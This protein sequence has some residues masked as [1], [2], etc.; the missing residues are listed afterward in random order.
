MGSARSAPWWCGLLVLASAGLVAAPPIGS[1]APPDDVENR[2]ARLAER[3]RLWREAWSHERAREFAEALP[4]YRAV[5][6]LDREL[7]GERSLTVAYVLWR[8]YRCHLG[9]GDLASAWAPAEERRTI[10]AEIHGPE[11]WRVTDARLDLE[12]LSLYQGLTADQRTRLA[13]ADRLRRES[14]RLMREGDYPRAAAAG[15]GGLAIRREVLGSGHRSC[16]SV[17]DSLGVIYN[18]M[19]DYTRAE[20]LH[21]EAL[22]IWLRVLGSEHPTYARGL[23]YVA[24]VL[25]RRH[26][27]KPA[28][29]LCREALAICERT[30][31]KESTSTASCLSGLG[32]VLGARL[33]HQEQLELYRR[34]LAIYRRWYG[35]RSASYATGLFNVA[36]THRAMGGYAK[37]ASLLRR[38]AEIRK[39]V[40][41]PTHPQYWSVLTSLAYHHIGLGEFAEAERLCREAV[42]I[43]DRTV[44][45][46]HENHAA[47]LGLFASLYQA[48]GDHRKALPLLEQVARIVG[49]RWGQDHGRYAARLL[50]LAAAH[51]LLG[52]VEKAEPLVHRA[53]EVWKARVGEDHLSYASGLAHL[54]MLRADRDRYAEAEELQRRAAEIRERALGKEHPTYSS[55]LNNLAWLREAQGDL[56]GSIALYERALEIRRETC[57]ETHPTH[58]LVLYNLALTRHAAGDLETAERE[59]REVLRRRRSLLDDAFAIQSERQQLQMTRLYR[60]NLDSYLSL[61]MPGVGDPGFAYEAVL[62]WK[63]AIFAR[64]ADLRADAVSPEDRSRFREYERTCRRLATLGLSVPKPERQEACRARLRELTERREELERELSRRSAAFRASRETDR[65][66]PAGLRDALPAGA[67]LVDILEFDFERDVGWPRKKTRRTRL[68]AF[69]VSA[70][71]P[72]RF[73]DLGPVPPI[74]K[75]VDAWRAAL[76]RGPAPA[77]AE[78]RRLVWEPLREAIAGAEVV[79]VSPDGV[80]NRL[81][82]AALPG[83]KP[84]RFLL[85]EVAVAVVPVPRLL[86][87]LLGETAPGDAEPSLLLIGQVDYGPASDPGDR[88][89]FRELEATRPEVLAVRDSFETRH[90]D[91]RVMM[92]R[93]KKATETAFREQAPGHRW[94]HVATHGFFAPPSLRSALAAGGE[95]GRHPGL[96]SGLALAGANVPATADGDDGILTALEVA[97]LDLSDVEVA[98]LSACE[99]GLGEVAAGEGVMGLQRAFQVAGART[100]VTSLW[101][102]PDVATQLLMQRFYENLWDRGMGKLE[103]LRQAQ[104]WLMR[105]GGQRGVML[106]EESRATESKH[107]PP[108]FWAA[109][110]LS[111]DWR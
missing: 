99:T 76:E 106:P 22:A 49:E 64:Q 47:S 20:E 42:D 29:R 46:D 100:T 73:V 8:V 80:L 6:A 94:L 25:Q 96:L 84:G 55:S 19:L 38:V 102:V 50:E 54:A 27:L 65:L 33:L 45:E 59:Y 48:M 30:T 17:K 35:E 3:A 44:S 62:A 61:P 57:G 81:P 82:F 36:W 52:E 21:R 103:A 83:E 108:Y 51:R 1:A 92:L 111:G 31:G 97:A 23:R 24:A 74:A 88:P 11:D 60:G 39:D 18:Q 53:L 85:E 68:A 2:E 9:T 56:A 13:E 101:K 91:G 37:A 93:G 110:V 34:A 78:L 95:R 104:L 75:A 58:A 87:R 72:V 43:T 77:A 41:G 70:G 26:E 90:E 109:F 107:L 89:A 5:L 12:D 69:V 98:V 105:E 66:T 67:V 63:G 7:R 32:G 40:L 15:E 71:T 14:R 86:P 10:L 28:E 79:L 16:A 4:L